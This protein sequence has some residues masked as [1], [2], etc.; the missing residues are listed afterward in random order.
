MYRS[1]LYAPVPAQSFAKVVFP[2]TGGFQYLL[3]KSGCGSR[4]KN[5]KT[6]QNNC[7]T[8]FRLWHKFML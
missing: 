5:K 2:A 8:L 1:S 3:Q 6:M 4:R 7:L